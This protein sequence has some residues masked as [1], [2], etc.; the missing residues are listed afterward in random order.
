[1]AVAVKNAPE[2]SS[3]SL[4]DRMAV[5]S[6][7][8]V[9]YVLGSLGIVFGLVPWLWWSAWPQGAYPIVA[10][11]LLGLVMLAVAVGLA[12][13]GVRL[14]GPRAAVGVRGGIFLGLVFVLLAL[15]LARWV[16]MW[17]EYWAFYSHWFSPNTGAIITG[18]ATALILAFFLRLFLRPRME[19]TMVRLEQQGWFTTTGFKPLQGLRV[20]RGTI[21]GI[22]L[23]V[24]AGIYT[25]ISHGTLRRGAADWALNIPFTGKV[26]ID[27]PGDLTAVLKKDHED[28]D[29]FN[30]TDYVKIADPGSATELHTG[31]VVS[32][33]AFKDAVERYRGKE[34][35]AP[36]TAAPPNLVVM[37]RYALRDLNATLGDKVKIKDARV[38]NK[39]HAGD[40]VPREEFEAEVQRLKERGFGKDEVP[41][42]NP[43]GP[44]PASG[45]TTY[46]RL[47]LLPAVQFTV[48]LLLL[49]VSLWLAWR[50]VNYPT[51]ADFLIATEAELNKVSWTTQRRLVQDTIVVLVTV[52]LMSFYLFAMDQV[53][54]VVLSWKPIG[55]LQIPEDQAEKNI[56]VEDKRY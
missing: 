44:Q 45:P 36:P 21:F 38:S 24:G 10:K 4:L 28:K 17:V 2:V 19:K 55:V 15:L 52:F 35:A 42:L 31:E 51:F 33:E 11:S 48:P 14:L 32:R 41:S 18:V 50:V 20:R 43:A 29:V 34:G 54:R 6:L 56:S 30:T 13:V 25:M 49:V 9:V 26:S 53:W 7:V 12:I 27:N 39:F 5:V 3:S 40:V 22:L 37:D 1:M 47:V 46:R 16:S 23:L 8:G